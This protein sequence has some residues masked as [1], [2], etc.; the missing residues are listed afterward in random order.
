MCLTWHEVPV[1]ICVACKLQHSLAFPGLGARAQKKAKGLLLFCLLLPASCLQDLVETDHRSRSPLR[2][3]GLGIPGSG[4][5]LDSGE[6]GPSGHI[7]L[8]CGWMRA[9]L[10]SP[11]K[12]DWHRGPD[13]LSET[14]NGVT[15]APQV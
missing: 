8:L 12:Q 2:A 1:T 11:K 6:K 15:N 4:S 3:G 5:V 7:A 13:G 9:R 14:G 10:M